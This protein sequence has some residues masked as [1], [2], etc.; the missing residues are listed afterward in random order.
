[1]R[2]AGKDSRG[3]AWGGG[4]LALPSPGVPCLESTD[5]RCVCVW[6]G[7]NTHTHLP[8]Y[9]WPEFPRLQF[10]LHVFPERVLALLVFCQLPYP[11]ESG[12]LGHE[13]R[14]NGTPESR[15]QVHILLLFPSGLRQVTVLL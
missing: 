14:E 3:V 9:V 1:M 8:S 11:P 5:C 2:N 10:R 4:A 12:G 6:G 15:V 7:G 13:D